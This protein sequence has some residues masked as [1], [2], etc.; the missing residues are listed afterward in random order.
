MIEIAGIDHVGIGSDFDGGD[1]V[2]E[3]ADAGK[4]RSLA[5]AL[6]EKGL[7]EQD[8]HKIFSE[9]VRRVMQWSKARRKKPSEG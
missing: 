7:S 1:P 9:N 4:V 2:P 3:L 8:I 5:R 6:A